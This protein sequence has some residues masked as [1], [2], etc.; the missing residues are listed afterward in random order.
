MKAWRATLLLA[1]AVLA[2]IAQPGTVFTATGL[3]AG[4]GNWR[5]IALTGPTQIAVAPPGQVT[6]ARLSGGADGDQD[7]YNN[8]CLRYFGIN[9]I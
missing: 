8:L 4:A 6:A 5:M 1:A 3:D 2:A 7:P 9:I